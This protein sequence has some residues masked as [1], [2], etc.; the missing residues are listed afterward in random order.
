L[1]RSELQ[2]RID[3]VAVQAKAIPA[4]ARATSAEYGALAG[5]LGT[6]R[7]WQGSSDPTVR[8]LTRATIPAAAA[9]PRPT[10]TLVVAL[11]VG[12][13][14][15][16]AAAVALELVNPRVTREDELALSQRLP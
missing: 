11:V 3:Q 16:I 9:W 1:F 13:L 7:A 14:L 4:A 8:L 10:L 6:L 2:Q 15:G 5:Q 12:L